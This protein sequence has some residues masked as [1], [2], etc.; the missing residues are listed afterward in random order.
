MRAAYKLRV[1]VRLRVGA[2]LLEV[3]PELVDR[4]RHHA[5]FS[6]F[7]A[8]AGMPSMRLVALPL[9]HTA[10]PLSVPN[11]AFGRFEIDG[12]TARVDI[13]SESHAALAAIRLGVHLSIVRQ[14]GVLLHA[15]AAAF[16]LHAVLAVGPSGAGKSTLA[17]LL[18]GA[19]ATLL[20]DEIVALFPDGRVYGTPFFS[21]YDRPGDAEARRLSLVVTLRHAGEE[22]LEPIA[23]AEL[24][25][26]AAAQLYRPEGGELT[27]AAALP[28]LTSALRHARSGTLTFRPVPE[29]ATFVHELVDEAAAR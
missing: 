13:G 29:A 4:A 28:R 8:A 26:R 15:A 24:I 2:E 7:I 11:G 23:P 1:T 19:G 9:P 6:P 27:L 20:S 12:Q 25:S 22:S 21:D 17:R 10:R 16:G 14:G 3:P 5:R 18:V